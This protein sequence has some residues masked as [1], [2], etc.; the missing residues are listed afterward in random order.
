MPDS[1]LSLTESQRAALAKLG[2]GIEMAGG[3][4]L[5]CG[6]PGVGKT[7]VLEHLA[8]AVGATGRRV[9]LLPVADWLATRTDL[10]GLVLADDAHLAGDGEL[11]SLLVRCQTGRPAATLVL[12]GQGRLLTLAG[13]DRRLAEATQ[14]R[15]SLLPAS[16]SETAVVLPQPAGPPWS[17]AVI[18]RLHE[19]AAGIPAACRRLAELALVV[20]ASRPDG[21]LTP[22]DIEAVHRRLSPH[23]A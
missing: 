15:V 8:A 7:T 18:D 19:I 13:R 20:A 6:P 12:S 16:R 23:A 17:E 3:L 14:L 4:L 11:A 9:E 5:L 10:P 22:D 2:C 1:S 21:R